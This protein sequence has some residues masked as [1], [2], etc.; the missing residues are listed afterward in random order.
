MSKQFK[1][2]EVANYIVEYE[3]S[4]NRRIYNIK[5]QKLLAFLADE[6]EAKF[7]TFPFEES[8]ENW[9]LGPAVPV[10]Y[11]TYHRTNQYEPIPKPFAVTE[12]NCRIYYKGT[13]TKDEEAVIQHV[14][15]R[16]KKVTGF[17]MVQKWTDKEKYRNEDSSQAD[18]LEGLQEAV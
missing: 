11:R 2:M 17:K 12:G 14:C 1:A 7:N 8:F 6:W 18:E 9:F 13:F 10:V 3:I 4:K 16:F 15:E 5:L